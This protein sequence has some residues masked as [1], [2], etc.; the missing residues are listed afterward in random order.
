MVHATGDEKITFLVVNYLPN[1][2]STIP[3]DLFFNENVA[4][5][6]V[7]EQVTATLVLRYYRILLFKRPK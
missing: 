7:I 2:N 1:F 6:F 4:F 3:W 5:R